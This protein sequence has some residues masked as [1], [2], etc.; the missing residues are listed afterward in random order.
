MSRFDEE[1]KEWDTPESQE[2]AENIA[3]A[4]NKQV[5]LS[6]KMS[7]FEYGCGTGQ[8]SFELREKIGPIT[9]A[10]NSTGMLEVL[11]EKIRKR[12]AKDMKPVKL[13]LTSDPLPNQ[14]FDL[15][16]TMMTLHHIPDTR[17]ILSQFHK[18]LN[19]SGYLCIADLDKEDGSFH[20][21]DVNEVHNGFD[22]QEL[23]GL[24]KKVGFTNINFSTAYIME[25]E[26]SENGDTNTFPIFL[27][28]AQK[29]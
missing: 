27:M 19:P 5:H 23:A 14:Q 26:V 20:G 16:Y 12:A 28:V 7:A 13:D 24:A 10:D 8:L 17:L 3:D 15:V 22:R 21:H 29:A 18:L 9:L 25:K 2:R 4:I 1:A 6:K 11:Q